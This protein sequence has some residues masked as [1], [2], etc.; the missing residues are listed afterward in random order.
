MEA[1]LKLIVGV[2]G[3]TAEMLL[4]ISYLYAGMR[5]VGT[6]ASLI[7]AIAV[8]GM[9]FYTI[10]WGINR[11]CSVVEARIAAKVTEREVRGD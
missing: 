5:I 9:L 7:G 1:L 8:F 10:R 2:D 3:V 4:Q 11:N 6:I